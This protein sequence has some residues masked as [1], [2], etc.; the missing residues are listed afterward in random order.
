MNNNIDVCISFDT[1]GSMYPC[2]TQVRRSVSQIVR[3]LFS[4]IP[5]LRISII[6][7]GDYCDAGDPYVIKINDFSKDENEIIKFINEVEPTYGGDAPECY[8][9]VLNKARTTLSWQSGRAKILV[10]IGDDVPHGPS[11]PSNVNKIDWRNELGLILEAGINVYAIHALPGIRKHSKPFYEEIAN[12]TGGFYLTL[13]QFSNV[14]DLIMAICY[15]Q[16]GDESLSAFEQQLRSSGKMN[17]NLKTSIRRLR[18]DAIDEYVS[19]DGLMPVPDGRFQVLQVDKDQSI[20]EFIQ[21]QGITFKTGRGFY[22]LT[23]SE[24]V[25]L[26]KEVLLQEKDTGKLFNGPQIRVMLGLSPQEDTRGVNETLKPVYFD[27]YK[28]FV[29]STSYNRKLI[30]NT[31]LLYE[32]DDWDRDDS[33]AY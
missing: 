12:K 10:L 15:K 13:D 25:Q 5:D 23:K 11:Y 19:S 31:S 22:E 24:K 1:T 3:K 29:Q 18:N 33:A 32:V 14:S 20:K 7:H 27:K 28:V 6:A 30:A 8:E 17:Y 4:D 9:L 2:L 21:E 16:D 26:Y